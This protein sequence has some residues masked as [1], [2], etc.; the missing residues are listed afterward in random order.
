[1]AE[2]KNG[3]EMVTIKN[4]YKMVDFHIYCMRCKNKDQPEEKDPCDMC[5]AVP[6]RE[7]TSKPL[8]FE[9]EKK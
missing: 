5:L 1:M 7:G 8:C 2:E 9:E 6:A 3:K 4:D